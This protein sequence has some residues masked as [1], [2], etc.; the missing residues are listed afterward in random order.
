MNASVVI[1]MWNGMA[2]IRQCLD[3]VFTQEPPAGEVIVVDNASTDG[4]AD[5]VA[6]IFPRARLIRNARNLGFAAACNAGLAASGGDV[7]V[8]LNQDT[9]VRSNWLAALVEGL[10]SDPSIGVAGAKALYPDG[11]IQHAGGYLDELGGGHHY[12]QG[13]VDRGQY[14]LEQDVAYVTGASLAISRPAL[15]AIGPLDENYAPAYFEDVDWCLRARAAGLRVRYI[16]RAVMVHHEASMLADKSHEGM[17]LPHRNRLRLVLKH[18]SIERLRDEF[19]PA[20]K[21]CIE[22][23]AGEGERFITAVHHA[24]LYQLLNLADILAWRHRLWGAEDGDADTI[25]GVLLALRSVAPLAVSAMTAQS[26]VED[27]TPV[28][29][30][31]ATL[32]RYHAIQEYDFP[33]QTPVVGRLIAAF[34]RQWN[35]VS[36]QWYV[37]AMF[38]QQTR[39]NAAV[40]VALEQLAKHPQDDRKRLAAYFAENGRELAELALA[41]ERLNERKAQE[42]KAK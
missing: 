11:T 10:A 20:E 42:D 30:T 21:R 34:R 31:L 4:S 16:P 7:L 36:T 8:L 12:G 37:R 2:Y 25:A 38:Q 14:D 41:I 13:Q 32:R 23:Q 6:Q 5:L 19:L 40:V 1:P 17:Y 18:W 33:A 24:Y 22:S 35:R 26:R 29:E 39:F 9:I 28:E 3:A 27:H 15:E